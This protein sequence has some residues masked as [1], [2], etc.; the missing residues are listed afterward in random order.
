[1]GILLHLFTN[2]FQAACL[3]QLK[4]TWKTFSLPVEI[5]K[6]TLKNFQPA[7][8]KSLKAAVGW[9]SQ[10]TATPLGVD[11]TICFQAVRKICLS[12]VVRYANLTVCWWA[13]KPT[14][15]L[16]R[17]AMQKNFQVAL[18]VIASRAESTAW[19]S[20]KIIFNEWNEVKNNFWVA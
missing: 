12:M 18:I 8:L 17:T 9:A 10:P 2:F 13:G 5:I 7:C 20:P 1:M 16:R 14:L 6:G 11:T 3:K 4:A 15:R 19:Q